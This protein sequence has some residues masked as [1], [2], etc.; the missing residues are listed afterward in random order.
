MSF[1]TPTTSRRGGPRTQA[2]SD[3]IALEMPRQT[4]AD[5]D[6]AGR[7]DRVALVEVPARDERNAERGEIAR[8]DMVERD[9]DALFVGERLAVDLA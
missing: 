7:A 1:A 8:R 4:L 5:D 2:L 9:A 6:H 3:W